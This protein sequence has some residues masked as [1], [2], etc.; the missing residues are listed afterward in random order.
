MKEFVARPKRRALKTLS[1][2]YAEHDGKVSDK[3]SLYLNVYE[4]LFTAFRDKP[5]RI[6]EIGVQNGGSLEIWRKFFRNANIIVG[7]DINAECGQLTF[8]SDKIALIV[9]DANTSE[10]ERE[11]LERSAEYDIVI[12]DGSHKSSDIIRSFT[13]YFGHVAEGGIYV[14]EDLHCSYWKKYE[15]GLYDPY[16]SMSFF[17]RLA[18]AVN[19]EHWGIARQRT[20]ILD[21]FAKKFCVTFDEK[22]LAS[23]HS[24]E[25]SNS[26]CILRKARPEENE[27][28]RRIIAG[29]HAAINDT[30]VQRA[31]TIRKPFDQTMNRWS[32]DKITFEE[33]IELKQDLVR[34]QAK[35]IDSL[36]RKLVDFDAAK[37]Q[38][39]QD[40]ITLDADIEAKHAL[41]RQQA[42]TIGALER[43]LVDFDANQAL[44]R[45]QAETLQRSFDEIATLTREV[46]VSMAEQ[47]RV[48]AS[49]RLKNRL[50]RVIVDLFDVR[51]W[52]AVWKRVFLFR[53]AAVLKR[54][55]FDARWYLDHNLD[56]AA[57]GVDP[58]RHYI[59]YGKR[60]GRA[61]NAAVWQ[62]KVVANNPGRR[63]SNSRNVEI[64]RSSALF[65]EQWYLEAYPDVKMLGMNPIQHYLWIG[66]RLG[67]NP[68]IRFDGNR[69]LAM[70][71]DVAAAGI[72]PLLHYARSGKKER[73]RVYSVVTA[74]DRYK[75][76]DSLSALF[77]PSAANGVF[78]DKLT[79]IL[80]PAVNDDLLNAIKTSEAALEGVPKQLADLGRR[81]LVSVIMPTFNRAEIIGEAI[82]S[83]IEQ[84]YENWELMV[85]DDGSTD[86]TES[87]VAQ[88]A[89]ARI[90]YCKLD[91]RGAAAARN[92]GLERAGGDIF[93]YL[94]SDNIWHPRFLVRMVLALLQQEGH[95]AV[96]GNFI[97]YEVGS[98]DRIKIN[99][100]TRPNFN[101]E[102]LLKKNYIDLNSFVHQRELF[103]CFGGFNEAL[104]RRQ[105]YDLIIKYTWL[106]DAI[107][108]KELLTLYQRN[109]KLDQITHVARRD[110]TCVSIIDESIQGYLSKGLPLRGTRPIKSVTILSWDLCRNHFS[111]PFAL[112]EALSADYDVQLVSFR[113][114]NEEIFP[115]L[116]GVEPSFETVYLQG[117][118]FPD[119]FEAMKTAVDAIRG[120]VIYVVKPRLSKSW[121]SPPRKPAQQRA[122]RP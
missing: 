33:D 45:Q 84:E 42:D 35:T 79:G 29:R 86:H 26:L 27:L 103:D 16:S 37:H 31:G 114:F 61:P 69:Y 49:L 43:K 3:W 23:I 59:Q 24:I 18:D 72:N 88:F 6:L 48:I 82:R 91:K 104:T 51:R 92:V 105:D 66:W 113:F 53:K 76:K 2:L 32:L 47:A 1:E 94:D 12:D 116:K 4:H 71:S 67:R 50:G 99:S 56:V 96:Y 87:I 19:S 101:H 106:R 112:A 80:L 41:T 81:P 40:K 38:W 15:G 102:E 108:A 100:Y 111:K 46:N 78:F 36:Q 122:N 34:E 11:I 13:R 14:A 8:S 97:D 64:I 73:R 21:P 109:K 17:K 118:Q 65:D 70:Y 90:R 120:D 52:P 89:D 25:F 58:A 117:S 95:S 20:D 28:G 22:L 115:P 9:G 85:C 63:S 62:S 68:S 98:N 121:G 83:V 5:V 93:A 107:Y 44:A 30:I 110:S 55:K 60:E 74:D 54:V 75:L 7:C 77:S 57:A 10:T 39:T 119:F